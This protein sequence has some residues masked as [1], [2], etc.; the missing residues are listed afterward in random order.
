MDTLYMNP[1]TG[2]ID[3][4]DGWWYEDEHGIQVNAVDHNEVIALN[5][6]D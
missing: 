1:H 5:E 6:E 3:D 2:S 4:Y